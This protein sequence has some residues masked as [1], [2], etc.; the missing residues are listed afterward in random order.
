MNATALVE[1]ER[2]AD[3]LTRAVVEAARRLGLSQKSLAATLGVSEATV[4]RWV[5]G[6]RLDPDSKSG[7]LAI[8]LVRLFRSLD[9]LV[10]GVEESCRA[11]MNAENLHLGGKPIERIRSVTGLIDVTQYLDSMRGKS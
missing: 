2:R 6:Q 4:S 7:E 10:G 5:R 9:S 11:W 8:L 3:I 1:H